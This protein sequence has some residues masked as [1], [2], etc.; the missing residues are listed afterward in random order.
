MQLKNP[1]IFSAIESIGEHYRT[2]I[3]NRFTRRALSSMSLDQ[4]TWNLIEELTEKVDN[5]R[6]QGYHLDELYGQILALSRFVYQAR[7]EVV[8]SLRY[9]ATTGNV[10]GRVSDSDRVFRDMAVN[11]FAPNL[12]ILADKLNELYV[13]VAAIDKAAAGQRT[14][15][16]GQLAELHE[17]GRYLVE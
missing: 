9:T 3:S 6:Y 2:N 1:E 15:V 8:P 13:K 16:Y 7:R 12:K 4:G 14:P 10:S 11:N 17:I 5:Y